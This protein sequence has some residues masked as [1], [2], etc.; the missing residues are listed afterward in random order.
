MDTISRDEAVKLILD[1]GGR[2]FGVRF[3]KRTTGER[4]DMQCRLHV[5]KGV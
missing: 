5:S 4:R 1:S 2:I 3:F